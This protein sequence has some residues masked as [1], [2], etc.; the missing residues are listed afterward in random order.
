[1]S[2]ISILV[3]LYGGYPVLRETVKSW[4]A[5]ERSGIEFIVV[6]HSPGALPSDIELPQNSFYEWDPSNPGFASGVNRAAKIANS[7]HLLLLNPDVYLTDEA[8]DTITS[9]TL[10][11]L[12]SVGL[13]TAGNVSRGIDYAWWG[14]CRDRVDSRKT[15]VG[16][17]GGAA[18][19]SRHVFDDVGGFPEH[20]FAW[21]EDAEWALKAWACGHRTTEIDVVLRHVGGHS[22]AS[23][24]GQRLK[25]RLLARNRVATF[26]RMLSPAVQILFFMPFVVAL[27]ANVIRKIRQRTATSYIR[28]LYEGIVMDIPILDSPRVT[29]HVWMDI[30]RVRGR[31][32]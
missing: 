7:P 29:L 20:L 3:V 31:Q 27:V 14:F 11:A 21:G 2:E 9:A 24:A 16:P 5:A 22:V 26:R 32:V 13:S 28:G 1:M 10:P 6:D 17:S 8:V 19:I 30:I 18:L 4:K 12:G 23:L 15:L 25:A